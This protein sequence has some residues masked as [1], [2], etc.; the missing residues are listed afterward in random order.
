[1]A[2]KRPRAPLWATINITGVCNLECEYCFFQPRKHEHMPMSSFK[3]VI[4]I[5]KEQELFFLTISGG[6]PFTHP[7]INDILRLAH[8]EFE[9]ATVLSNGTYIKKRHIE[10]MKEIIRKK[11]CFPMQVSLDS[12]DPDI[13]DRTR[14]MALKVMK[15]LEALADAGV[16]L[17]IAVVVTSQN[18]AKVV[19]TIVSLKNLTRHFHVM[20]FKSVPFLDKGDQYL[21]SEMTDM[22][23]FWELLGD[24]RE[25]HRLQI[26]LPSD[27]CSTAKY[28]A[29]GAPCVAG[30]TQVVID[31]DLDVR[32]C[33]RC[34]HAIAG[35]LKRESLDSIWHGPKLARIYQRD[36]PYCHVSSEWEAALKDPEFMCGKRGAKDGRNAAI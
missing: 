28:S 30:F 2:S 20:P 23:K 5:L 26:R 19:D 12:V 10:C 13:N 17:T 36:I 8:D 35:N 22:Q 4:D 27:E 7:L 14:G 3:K 18:V 31:P 16:A 21:G 1:M 32:A 15:N 29:T 9:H 33:S 25:K 34:T 11:G 24:I 6:E